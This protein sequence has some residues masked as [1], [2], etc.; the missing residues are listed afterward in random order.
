VAAIDLKA[1]EMIEMR[2]SWWSPGGHFHLFGRSWQRIKKF[3][4]MI[5]F[6]A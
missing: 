1:A 6:K 3:K 5:I 2:I 4:N